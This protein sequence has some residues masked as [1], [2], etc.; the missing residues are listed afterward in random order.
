MSK[1]E[2]Y[3]VTSHFVLFAK[4]L[5]FLF[6][7]YLTRQRSYSKHLLISEE[8]ARYLFIQILSGLRYCHEHRVAHRDITLTNILCT[9]H[10]HPVV[11]VRSLIL[12]IWSDWNSRFVILGC[13]RA[14][15]LLRV[16]NPSP[17]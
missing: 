4:R 9:K 16:L 1:E 13:P 8:H 2:T 12:E 14:G 15:N 11:K 6:L 3:S 7:D 5:N 17:L 10:K